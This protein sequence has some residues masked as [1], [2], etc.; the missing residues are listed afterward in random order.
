MGIALASGAPPFAGIIAGVVGGLVVASLSGSALGV[1]GPAAGLAVMVADAI[2]D[3]GSFEVF[4][5]AVII[6]GVVQFIA[7]VAKAGIIGHY[8]PTAV[9]KG[10]L[11]GIGVIIFLKQIPHALGYDPSWEG[12]LEFVQQDGHNTFEEIYYAFLYNSEGA[13][14]ITIVSLALLIFWESKWIQNIKVLKMLPGPLLVVVLGALLNETYQYWYPEW[15]L[16]NNEEVKHLVSLPVADSIEGFL[17]LLT[18]PDFSALLDPKVY[19][20]G[21]TIAVVASLETLLSVE[22]TDKL[23][24]YKR[25]TSTNRELKAQGIGNMV[26][27]LVG[28]LPVT[29]VI[30]RSAANVNS[31]GKTRM[32][33]I[34]HGGFLLLCVAL[35]PVTLNKIPLA[36]L[37][38]VLLM[39]GYKL[40]NP[41]LFRQMYRKGWAQFIPFTV[42]VLGLV[43]TDMLIGIGL[44]MAVAIFIILKHNYQIPYSFRKEKH[45]EGDKVVLRL[46]EEVSFLNKAQIKVMLENLPRNT[47]LLI[48]GSRS[49]TIDQDV[50]EIIEGFIA[51]AKLKDIQVKVKGIK[52]LAI[53]EKYYLTTEEGKK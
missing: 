41:A 11:A 34:F 21:M 17:G 35:I 39:I 52:G 38:A 22:A 33:A 23:D 30:I 36:S 9:I 19:V 1:S 27:G 51:H 45:Q 32:S 48:D 14:L 53:E 43:F 10:M 47:N 5:L 24:P 18:F 20:A 4:L 6:T 25:V 8:F 31:G 2:M 50:L 28:G 37:A 12:E 7:G 46:A 49:V 44:G 26:S 42:T 15:T 16:D 3:L 13:I 40:A 29:Q